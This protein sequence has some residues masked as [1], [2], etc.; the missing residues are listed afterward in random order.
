MDGRQ[1]SVHK[2]VLADAGET[3]R[4]REQALALAVLYIGSIAL[5]FLKWGPLTKW[6][7]ENLASATLPYVIGVLILQGGGPRNGHEAG[8]KL[9][10]V[11]TWQAVCRTQTCNP[12]SPRGALKQES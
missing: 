1:I 7:R 10:P 3:K 6:G 9:Y 5:T 12:Y 11:Q 2:Y 4:K 8:V